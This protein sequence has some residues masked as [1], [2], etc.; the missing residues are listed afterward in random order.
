[1]FLIYKLFLIVSFM[2]RS[3]KF[4][5]VATVFYCTFSVSLVAMSSEEEVLPLSVMSRVK[6]GIVDTANFLVSSDPDPTWPK[7]T[8]RLS[9]GVLLY[10]LSD[11]YVNELD[12]VII[13]AYMLH[14]MG[15]DLLKQA[16]RETVY[17]VYDS[18]RRPRIEQT[19]LSKKRQYS[20][21]KIK[22]ENDKLIQKDNKKI[23]VVL[24]TL[25]RFTSF[26]CTVYMSYNFLKSVMG[27]MEHG[28]NPFSPHPPENSS[29]QQDFL[30]KPLAVSSISMA[31]VLTSWHHVR[32]LSYFGDPSFLD[33]G[34][35]PIA[36]LCDSLAKLHAAM[37]VYSPKKSVADKYLQFFMMKY[38]GATGWK[39]IILTFKNAIDFLAQYPRIEEWSNNTGIEI[40]EQSSSQ[41]E[42]LVERREEMDH[43][44]SPQSSFP[45][46]SLKRKEENR[47]PVYRPGIEE[48]ITEDPV[49]PAKEKKKTR[50]PEEIRFLKELRLVQENVVEMPEIMSE[51]QMEHLRR[52]HELRE[53][54][55]VKVSKIDDELTKAK[56]FLGARIENGHGSERRFVWPIGSK[57]FSLKFEVPHGRDSTNYSGNK[58][59]RVL[60]MLE[61]CYLVGSSKEA[62]K[63][64]IERYDRW[65]LRRLKKFMKALGFNDNEI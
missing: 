64:Y 35:K 15:I 49:S 34:D 25:E 29:C 43:V 14:L 57:D 19:V 61:L 60:N 50:P 4:G 22:E 46:S 47:P 38:A 39:S 17:L 2:K 33:R 6:G 36:T 32:E 23:A 12:P 53:T 54:Y 13:P 51:V 41:A 55:P 24:K 1:M 45:Q 63:D 5:I 30:C 27:M 20:L 52:I 62:I 40:P 58:L 8:Y 21:E 42:R 28:V 56:K 9:L 16:S 65:D 11:P 59:D 37:V 3:I 48:S 10:L 18:F 31:I 7:V 44:R 26:V